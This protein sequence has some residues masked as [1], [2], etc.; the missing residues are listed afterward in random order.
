MANKHRA[1]GGENK[2]RCALLFSRSAAASRKASANIRS[3]CKAV[4]KKEK[5]NAQI[6]AEM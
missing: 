3:K 1:T 2:R 5:Y 4:K 6:A